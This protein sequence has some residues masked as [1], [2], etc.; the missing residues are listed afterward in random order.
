MWRFLT[1]MLVAC[2][3]LLGLTAAT[4]TSSAGGPYAYGVGGGTFAGR[5]ANFDMSMHGGPNGPFGH[6]HVKRDAMVAPIDVYVTV[7][8][9]H[10]VS[11]LT[12]EVQYS[13]RVQGVSPIPNF[14]ALRPGDPVSGYA[15]DGGNPSSGAPVDAITLF[16]EAVP[17]SCSTTSS[18]LKIWFSR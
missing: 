8:C 1:A 15:S 3:S 10:G 17:V 13:G 16:T 2:I 7:T 6:L 11:G 18:V 12:P 4:G 9:V 14:L 5:S